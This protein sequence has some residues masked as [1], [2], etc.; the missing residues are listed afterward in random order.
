MT[1]RREFFTGAGG[2]CGRGIV[3]PSDLRKVNL[4]VEGGFPKVNL[5]S[6]TGERFDFYKD[7][8]NGKVFLIT[9]MSL[10]DEESQPVTANLREA[11]RR[12]GDDKVGREIF[13][14]TI[15]LDPENDTIEKLQKFAAQH[16]VPNGWCFL[17]GDPSDANAV[18]QRLYRFNKIGPN[19]KLV[20]Y[21]NAQGN[22]NAWGSF[23]GL[24][25]PNDIAERITW[26][27][28]QAR[29]AKLRRA[30]PRRLWTH[31]EASHNREV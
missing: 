15:T 25:Q 1:S 16:S 21:G 23:P 22:A 2:F 31:P 6:H 4:N 8:V 27:M 12:L 26:V 9:F 30:G 3:D 29:P 13:I 19:P 11:I 7:R 14:N 24:I 17:R 28:P 20:F 5:D 18:Q 10:S